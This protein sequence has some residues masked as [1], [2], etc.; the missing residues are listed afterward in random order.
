MDIWYYSITN[1][2]GD[3]ALAIMKSETEKYVPEE[4]AIINDKLDHGAWLLNPISQ[5]EFETY[6]AFGIREIKL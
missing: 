1:W 6:Q 3:E 5:A 2:A 4:I